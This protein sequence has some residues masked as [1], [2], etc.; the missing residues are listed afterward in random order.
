[1][2][3]YNC[4][5]REIEFAVKISIFFSSPSHKKQNK[6]LLI[7]D[8]IELIIDRSDAILEV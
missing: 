6:A 4:L 1:M 2:G 8:K 7:I 3:W 5:K